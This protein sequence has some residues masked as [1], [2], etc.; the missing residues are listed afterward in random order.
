MCLRRRGHHPG[1]DAQRA[2]PG[3]LP[4]ARLRRLAAAAG[5][6]DRDRRAGGPSATSP[7]PSALPEHGD[8]AELAGIRRRLRPHRGAARASTSSCPTGR[9]WRCSAPTAPGKTTLLRVAAGCC[10][11]AGHGHVST[12]G[13]C[14]RR[15]AARPGPARASASIP[16]GRGIFRQLTVRENLAMFAGGRRRGRGVDEAV[17]AFPMLGERLDQEAGHAV[18]RP[19]A[20]AGAVP[21]ARA[22]TPPCPGRRAVGRARPGRRRRDLRGRRRTS[23]TQ[24]RSLLIVEQYVDRVLGRRRLR[25]H[26]AQGPGRLRRRTRAVPG[27]HIFERYLGSVA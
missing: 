20:D 2:R 22:P 18:R 7:P 26:P 15:A 3:A 23:R 11:Q 9:P 12:G 13:R 27:P 5:L 16:E 10:S 19:A 14:D 24:G 6:A 8:A 17:A 4:A 21:G 1:P 25:L